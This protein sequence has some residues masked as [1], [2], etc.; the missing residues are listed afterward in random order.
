MSVD[1]DFFMYDDESLMD[2]R[3]L[4]KVHWCTRN[5]P[6]DIRQL[7]KVSSI[8]GEKPVDSRQLMKVH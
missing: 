5:N 8:L 7:A 2:F 6:M 1:K 3:Q 4:A